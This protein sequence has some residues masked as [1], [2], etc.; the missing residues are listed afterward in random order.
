VLQILAL[1]MNT[2]GSSGPCMWRKVA[3]T[4]MG[5]DIDIDTDMDMGHGLGN[6]PVVTLNW[7]YRVSSTQQIVLLS[8][9]T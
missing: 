1:P 4:D 8:L 5:A 6:F 9:C 2:A 3:D 7:Y